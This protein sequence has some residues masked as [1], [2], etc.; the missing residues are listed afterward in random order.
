[1]AVE[2]LYAVIL[3]GG[4]GTR[5]WPLGRLDVPKQ[6][7]KI[8]GRESLLQETIQRIK[9]LVQPDHIFIVT[10]IRYA[11]QVK[12]QM[13]SFHLPGAN[14]LLEPEGKNTAPAVAW[15]G[16]RIHRLNPGAIMMVLPS[17]HLVK[18][19]QAFLEN[20]KEASKL[21][22]LGFLVTLGIPPTRPETGYGY[23]KT[24][25]MKFR[26][27]NILK[28]EQF[29][30]KPPLPQA[31]QF[32]RQ[33]NYLWNSGLFVWKTERILMSFKEFLPD[34]YQLF[35][36]RHSNTQITKNWQC[37]PS[38]SI[39]YGILE[40]ERDVVC[41]LASGIGWS[42]LGSWQALWE[43]LPKN[44][45]GN[46]FKGNTIAVDCQNMLVFGGKRLVTTIGLQD[47][48]IVDTP[49][50]LLICRRDRSQEVRDVVVSLKKKNRPEWLRK[51][52]DGF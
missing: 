13:M 50:A 31:R 47:L 45:D 26:G 12:E 28:V 34:M 10:N 27:K 3:A 35:E 5:F 11:S 1:M 42:D 21:A 48:T 16:F 2:N 6:F 22:D 37:L 38:V 24:Q 52:E 46:V 33:K 23:L 40:K 49:D 44:K 43:V 15:A 14:I 51:K 30:E 8:T 4:S 32:L 19:R 36:K 25:R 29:V 20:L 18:N 17:D 39:D 41:V 9:P 7:L